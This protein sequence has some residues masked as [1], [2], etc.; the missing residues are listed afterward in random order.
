MMRLLSGA[1]TIL[2]VLAFGCER[3]EDRRS[4]DAALKLAGARVGTA[5]KDAVAAVR[6]GDCRI[7]GVAGHFTFYPG[8]SIEDRDALMQRFGRRV[9][10]DT[11]DE[12]GRI[13]ERAVE[14]TAEY[15]A[16]YNAAILV[17]QRDC[18]EH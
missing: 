14:A 15:V 13:D 10:R 7:L 4:P 11:L 2:A 17:A 1:S 5:A 18:S 6:A 16:R 9:L 3:P 12:K 8:L